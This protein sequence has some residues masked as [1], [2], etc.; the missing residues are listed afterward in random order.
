MKCYL[1]VVN[2]MRVALIKEKDWPEFATLWD[3]N[4]YFHEGG[5]PMRFMKYSFDGWKAKGLD[6]HSLVADP[7]FVD[8]KNGDFRLKPGSPALRLGFKPID[9][10][11][12]GPRNR[13]DAAA[14]GQRQ[15]YL[16]SLAA[17]H[18]VR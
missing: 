8:P 3:Y 9:V 4:L 10:S 1:C 6:E 5:E 7:L 11:T 12:V 17:L 2:Y 16:D 14:K 15:Q 18:E 13:R